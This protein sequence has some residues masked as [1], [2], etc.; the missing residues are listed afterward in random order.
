M[1]TG[2]AASVLDAILARTRES[3]AREKARRPLDAGHPDVA[4]APAVRPFAAALA[5]P[6]AITV[7]AE[8]KR[9]SPSRGVDP[10]GPARRPT[11]RAATR[12]RAPRRSRS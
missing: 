3:V 12:P 10:R 8:L 6:G 2:A 4:R 1:S 9:R 5:R 11:S 7:I